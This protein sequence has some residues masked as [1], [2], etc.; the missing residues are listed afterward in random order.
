[1]SI[2]VSVVVPEGAL[3]A[4]RTSPAEFAVELTRAAVC[5]W[6]E[7]GMLSQS[8][9]AEILGVSRAEL[10]EILSRYRVTAFQGDE[11]DLAAE[12]AGG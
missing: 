5:K 2:T 3:S 6:Y 12:L 11:D 9:A 7:L 10:L 8:K 4:L 1:M